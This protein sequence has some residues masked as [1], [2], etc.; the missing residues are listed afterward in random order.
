MNKEP[1]IKKFKLSNKILQEEKL[2]NLFPLAMDIFI[3]SFIIKKSF[4]I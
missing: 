4:I 3:I 1:K 2:K